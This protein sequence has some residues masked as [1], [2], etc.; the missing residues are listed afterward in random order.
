[1]PAPKRLDPSPDIVARFGSMIRDLRLRKGW[2]R[3]RL[4]KEVALSYSA[5][6][7]FEAGERIPTPDIAKALD[8]VLDANGALLEEWDHLNN[9][10]DARWARRLEKLE[11]N[12]GAIHHLA[13]GIPVLLQ[14][15]NYA[16]AMLARGM[17][18]FG[19]DLEEKV[20][21]RMR[22]RAVL[23]AP[24]PPFFSA[25]INE[26]ALCLIAGTDAVMREQLEH[27]V[28][29]SEQPHVHLHVVPFDSRGLVA[30]GQVTVLFP[31]TGRPPTLYT[32]ALERGIFSTNSREVQRHEG[33]YDHVRRGALPETESR[34]FIRK[35]VKE[36][37]PCAY[38]APT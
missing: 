26:A 16:R 29:M 27:L 5:I 37:Y 18:F 21:Y 4:G 30:P 19:G 25:V 12:A 8:R 15:E 7:K 10:P 28:H 9:G 31:R 11:A 17:E 35:T 14:T 13:V 6:A 22:R 24:D 1:M 32:V 20:Q 3:T 34:T 2:S 36:K 38:P 33:L 23:D